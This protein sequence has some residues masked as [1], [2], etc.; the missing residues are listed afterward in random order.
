MEKISRFTPVIFGERSAAQLFDVN[1]TAFCAHVKARQLFEPIII[2]SKERSNVE[3][4]RKIVSGA[5]LL[6]W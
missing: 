4:L 6:Q 2:R 1:R 3:E 5:N